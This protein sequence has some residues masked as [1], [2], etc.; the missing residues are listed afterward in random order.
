MIFVAMLCS[1]TNKVV[2]WPRVTA[3]GLFHLYSK[4]FGGIMPRLK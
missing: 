2:V 3:R 1:F 4:A